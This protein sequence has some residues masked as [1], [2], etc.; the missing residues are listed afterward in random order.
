MKNVIE[1]KNITKKYKNFKLGEINAEIP[2][3]FA[4][5]LIGANGAGKTTLIDIL[6]GVTAK[7]SGEAVYFENMTNI[8]DPVLRNKIG[9]TSS[10]DFFPADWNLK[11]IS[12]SMELAFDNFSKE[13]FKEMCRRFKLEDPDSKKQ[14]KLFQ[15]S[16]GNKMRACLAAILA[17]NTDLLVLDEPASSLDPLARDLLCDLF[18]EY[19]AER[20]GERSI[21]F[22][23]HN[24]ADMEFVTDYTVFMSNGKVIEQGFVEDLKQ[25]YILVH[26][27]IENAEAAKPYMISASCGRTSFDGI[28]YAK[29]SEELKCC[30]AAI[31]M[32]S[33]QQLSVGILKKDDDDDENEK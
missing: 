18:R 15:M 21:L 23:T 11:K 6:C 26:G 20:D 3:G 33:L 10:A 27:D 2:C 8:D 14:K 32:P 25:K 28:A 7:N 17:R 12:N 5:A 9:Y 16:D 24:I 22:S 31:E 30:D 1:I 4:T 19:L 29:N 13:K